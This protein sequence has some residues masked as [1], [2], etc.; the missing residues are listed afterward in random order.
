M[1]QRP[2]SPR[3]EQLKQEVAREKRRRKAAAPRSSS[4]RYL[5]AVAGAALLIGILAME[6]PLGTSSPSAV[7]EAPQP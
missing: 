3:I 6:T 4:S 7:A 5:V 1:N 2:I